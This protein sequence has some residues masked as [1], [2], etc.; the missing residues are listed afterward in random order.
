MKTTQSAGNTTEY[1]RFM[2]SLLARPLGAI[3]KRGDRDGERDLDHVIGTFE[4][5]DG[6]AS[7]LALMHDNRD[8]V[9]R[10]AVAERG[11]DGLGFGIV[12]GV[13]GAEELDGASPACPEPG[14]WVGD[15]LLAKQADPRGE[16]ADAHPPHEGG[17]E[18]IGIF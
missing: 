16:P 4:R 2:V 13:V 8:L 9:H 15:G 10:E 17:L 6:G 18:P 12:I 11:D 14:G 3:R 7:A 5:G 1:S